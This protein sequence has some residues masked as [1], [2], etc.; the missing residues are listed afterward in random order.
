MGDPDGMEC[1]PDLA[2]PMVEEIQQRGEVGRKIIFLPYKQ[3]E[4][5]GRIGPVVMD[6]GCGETVALQLRDEAA[7][8]HCN[9]RLSVRGSSSDR[10]AAKTSSIGTARLAP[11][12]FRIAGWS[13]TAE[14]SDAQE[15]RMARLTSGS[16]LG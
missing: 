8:A 9:G 5:R 3:L 16:R 13:F 15:A 6:F 2:A 14:R 10:I 12:G 11:G 7:I 1:G 4:E